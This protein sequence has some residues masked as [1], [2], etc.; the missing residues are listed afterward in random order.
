MDDQRVTDDV[1]AVAHHQKSML[2]MEG[3][4]YTVWRG[5]TEFE[6][7]QRIGVQHIRS[8]LTFLESL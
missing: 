4:Q 3:R 2:V 7:L 8:L 5:K 6:E 1:A